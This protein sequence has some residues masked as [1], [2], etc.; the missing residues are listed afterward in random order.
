MLERPRR[1]TRI[2]IVI[3]EEDIA[4]PSLL[5][6]GLCASQCGDL[7]VFHVELQDANVLVSQFA[8]EP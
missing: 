4:D 5:E 2:T 1:F 3:L 7:M 8:V 6:Q